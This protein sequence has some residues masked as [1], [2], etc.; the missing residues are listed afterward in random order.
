MVEGKRVAVRVLE[1]RL[2]ADAGVERV[3][4]ERDAA[5]FKF[6]S[7]GLDVVDVQRDRMVV[8]AELEV[9]ARGGQ[10]GKREAARF[11]LRS[12]GLLAGA[13]PYAGPR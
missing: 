11:E 8:G 9:E 1:E 3:C 7:R 6:G 12:D 5:R 13:L 2:E 10:Q 4:R